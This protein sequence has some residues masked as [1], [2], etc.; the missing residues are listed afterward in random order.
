MKAKKKRRKKRKRKKRK[1]K[2]HQ[3][4]YSR[5]ICIVKLVL[6]KWQEP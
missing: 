6:G 4:L 1:K 3:R 2:S 5:L